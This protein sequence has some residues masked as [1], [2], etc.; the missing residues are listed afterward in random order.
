MFIAEVSIEMETVVRTHAA[1]Y[2]MDMC[3]Q[4]GEVH[5]LAE[6][7]SNGIKFGLLPGEVEAGSYIPKNPSRSDTR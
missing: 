6:G 2:L 4:F 5:V 1:L 7:I 3:D